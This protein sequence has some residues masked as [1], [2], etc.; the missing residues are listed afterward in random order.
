M[1]Y[2][3]PAGE[4]VDFSF[5]G[6]YTPPAYDAVD[7]VFT[8]VE[9]YQLAI[10]PVLP[11]PVAAVQLERLAPV[12][13]HITRLLGV[14]QADIQ[15]ALEWSRELRIQATLPAITAEIVLCRG[16]ALEV[17]AVLPPMGTSLTLQWGQAVPGAGISDSG[18]AR[19]RGL[20][21][22][23]ASQ[24]DRN[25]TL[26]RDSMATH[27]PTVRSHWA[28]FPEQDRATVISAVALARR[29]LPTTSAWAAGNAAEQGMQSGYTSPPA[30]DQTAQTGWDRFYL[31]PTLNAHTPYHYPPARDANRHQ[32]WMHVAPYR[33]KR[34]WDTRHYTVP[35]AGQLDFALTDSGYTPRPLALA[36][37]WG[38]A[39]T[40]GKQPIMPTDPGT[41]LAHDSPDAIDRDWLINW[42]AGSWSRPPPDYSGGD[43]WGTEPSEDRPPQPDI[44]QV[45]LFMPSILL[46]RL[47]DGAE[48]AATNVT[49]ATDIDSWG[50]RFSATITGKTALNLIRPD[51][52]GPR[53]IACEINGHTFKGVVESYSVNRSHANSSYSI[54][55]RSLSAWLSDPY[56]SLRSQ[57]VS[58]IFTARQLAEQALS[59]TGWTLDWQT[60]DWS[61]PANVFSYQEQDPI[62]V[63]KSIADAV[64]AVVQSHPSQQQLTVLPRYPVSPHR[65]ASATLNAILPAAL[66]DQAGSEFSSRPQYNRSFVTGGSSG[67]VIVM[68]TR[69]GTA[70]DI[71]TPQI[72]HELITDAQAGY[73]R[74]RIEIARGGTW[75]NLSLTTYLTQQGDAPGLLLPGYLVEL[76]DTDD[77]F[78]TQISGTTLTAQS[79]E[80]ALSVRQT[81]TAERYIDG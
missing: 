17:A 25:L 44:R 40:L 8:Q 38:A 18:S 35:D 24:A 52:N 12:E 79:T 72:T 53:E 34:V 23:K 1:S 62:A 78:I 3:A 45:Y 37:S 20:R 22:G 69:D 64:G 41:G 74:G 6:A 36:F 19:G 80:T 4:T 77:T 46:Y 63:I 70:G 59:N 16:A 57:A 21:W 9:T 73:E 28:R 2:T 55:G 65:W 31:S 76:Q 11:L 27:A 71:L 56:A 50:W 33:L 75:E 39:S 51:S 15:L 61:V 7:F 48:I 29:D 5:E 60:Q 47:P 68:T 54:K 49:W 58:E 42:G 14:L 81:L 30:R 13:L 10:Q 67:G 32:P 66:I 43:H 26:Q